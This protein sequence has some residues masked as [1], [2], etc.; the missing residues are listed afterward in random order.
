MS[1]LLLSQEDRVRVFRKVFAR[2]L[3]DLH[4]ASDPADVDPRQL[5]FLMAWQFPDDLA[6]RYPNLELV[7]ST[8]A[9]IDQ[10]IGAALPAGAR[11]VRMVESGVA[12]LVR[13]YVVMSVLALHRD[14]PGYLQQQRAQI[15][16]TRDFVWADQR[17]V[18]FLGL[19]EMARGPIE[20]L[21]GMGFKLAG[22]SRSEKTIDGVET[23]AG[24]DGLDAMLA[25]TDILVCLLPLTAETRHILDARL[26]AKLPRGA[27]LV[28]AGRGGHQDQ[29]ALLAA[30]DSGQLGAAFIDVA[31]TEPLPKGDPL[32][33][34]PRV[35]LT[36][37]AAGNTR[38]ETAAEATAANI[39][40][41]LDGEDPV[42]LVDPDKGY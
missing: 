11:L 28:Q 19:G 6:R 8:G 2:E 21:R 3:P 15:W 7:L 41:Y 32:W 17:R 34:H 12:S 30:L 23:Y 40:R 9:G 18:G 16:Q 35:I 31:E 27:G 22:W 5:R 1:F 10:L 37:H 4:F 26:F 13:D 20:V 39:R 25:G 38:A 14:L 33:S 24:P 36:P 42:G 29:A